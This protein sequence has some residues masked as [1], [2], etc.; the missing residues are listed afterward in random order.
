MISKTLSWL[1][2]C[3]SLAL[4][5]YSQLVTLRTLILGGSCARIIVLS[6]HLMIDRS[7]RERRRRYRLTPR[8]LC[9]L[10]VRVR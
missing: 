1:R 3:D 10:G 4:A 8:R 2:G 6:R 7:L 9:Y 5:S